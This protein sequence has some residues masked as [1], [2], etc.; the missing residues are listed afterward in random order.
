MRVTD[1]GG[2]PPRCLP[3]GVTVTLSDALRSKFPESKRAM[4]ALPA[5]NEAVACRR[6]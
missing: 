1:R 6:S 3:S 5:A 4:P 2:G